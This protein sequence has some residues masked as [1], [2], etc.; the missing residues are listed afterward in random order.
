MRQSEKM[1]NDLLRSSAIPD[2][3]S[4]TPVDLHTHSTRSDGTFSP[5]ELVRY[6]ARKGLGAI[7][8][9]DHD[10]VAGIAEAV[11]TA[12]DENMPEVIPGVELSTEY[13]GRDIH[14]V[15]L[16]PDWDDPAFA[17]RLQ[18]FA[19]ARIYRNRKMCRLLT[20]SGYPVSFEEL[21]RRFEDTVIARPHIAQYL[22]D[23]GLIGSVEEA[24]RKLIG[25]GCPCFV[26]REKISPREAVEFLLDFHGV[27]VLAHPLQYHLTDASLDQLVRELTDAGLMG[28]EV[29]Y[30]THKPC[31]T[32]ALM[33]TADRYGLV[34]SGGSDFHGTRK[35]NL[36]LGTGYGHMFVPGS[37]LGP[38][39]ACAMRNRQ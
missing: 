25:D 34:C 32:A 21:Y 14:I 16:F 24:F 26:P 9:T 11:N 28:I 20:Q 8:L 39:R 35:P 13:K 38:I 3:P 30:P 1:N 5:S 37:L 36:D 23:E 27:P 17:G 31:D 12:L 7:A 29:Y 2:L 4:S 19:D 18:S 22:V 6:A 15:G 10:T 33:R